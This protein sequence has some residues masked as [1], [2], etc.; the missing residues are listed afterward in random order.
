MTNEHT[1]RKAEEKLQQQKNKVYRRIS[2]PLHQAQCSSS[3]YSFLYSSFEL[4]LLPFYLFRMRIVDETRNERKNE[5]TG[6]YTKKI[7]V[8]CVCVCFD[9]DYFSLHEEILVFYF[10][11]ILALVVPS[12]TFCSGVQYFFFFLDSLCKLIFNGI[13]CDA[14][15]IQT[16]VTETTISFSRLDSYKK[17][18]FTTHS[19]FFFVGVTK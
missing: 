13:S 11:L 3:S 18:L 7:L 12:I 19:D 14:L 9:A 4:F 16:N 10:T 5:K 6:A 15:H 2:F 1:H 17:K 8:V